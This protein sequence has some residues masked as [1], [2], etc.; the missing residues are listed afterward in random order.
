MNIG[1]VI[2]VE[3]SRKVTNCP[4]LI[5]PEFITQPPAETNSPK[6]TPATTYIPGMNRLRI[7]AAD[8]A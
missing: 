3:I 2:L 4:T 8:I 5:S 1:I 7:N 6:E